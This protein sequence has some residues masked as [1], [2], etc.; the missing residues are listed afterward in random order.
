IRE[1]WIKDRRQNLG[2]GLLDQPIKNGWNPQR[3][4]APCWFWNLYPSYRRGLIR[5]CQERFTDSGPKR[6]GMVGEL[7]DSNAIDTGCA[8]IG[9]RPFPRRFQVL[10]G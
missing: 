4:H 2:D 3:A 10:F 5:T 7:F 6:S 1:G 8:V 9:L